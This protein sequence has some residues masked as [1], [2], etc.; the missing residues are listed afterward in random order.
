MIPKRILLAAGL[1]L[2]P[3]LLPAPSSARFGKNKVHYRDFEW[4]TIET[5]HF[6]IYYYDGEEE[7]AIRAARMAERA[8]Q[9]LSRILRHEIEEAVPV[10][11]YASHTDF[12]QTNITPGLIPEGTGGITEFSKRRV[13]LPFTGSYGEFDH[14]LTHEL[15]HAFQIDVLFG[16]GTGSNPFSFQPPL[17]FMEGMAE[18]LSIGKMDAHTEMW[19]RWTALEG[20]LIP[21]QYMNR[22][23]DIRVYRIGQAVW[24]FIGE[25]YGDEKI[26]EILRKSVHFRSVEMAFEKTLGVDLATLN[27]EWE[28]Y[29]KRKYF[30]TIVDLHRPEEHGRKLLGRE[31]SPGVHLAPAL[32]P[33][34][35]RVVFIKD[36]N[37]SKDIVMASAI[38]GEILDTL[39][40]GERSGDFESL[41]FFYTAIGWSPDGTRLAFPAKKGG[42]D[43][44]HVLAVESKEILATFRLGMDAIYSP[45]FH[46][47]GNRIVFSGSRGGKSDL[48]LVDLESGDLTQVTDDPHMARDPQWSPDGK[49]IA[50]VTDRGAGTDLENL[51]F[52]PPQVAI[53]DVGTGRVSLL[54]GQVGK[55]I[56]PQWGPEGKHLAF[57]SDR[58]GVSDIYVQ[59]LETDRLHRLT[60]L[61]T[62]VT[63]IIE[64]SPPISWSRSGQRMVFTTFTGQGWELYEIENPLRKMT[65]IDQFEP[66]ERIAQREPGGDE[67]WVHPDPATEDLLMARARP[68]PTFHDLLEPALPSLALAGPGSLALSAP[69]PPDP[70]MATDESERPLTLSLSRIIAE[71]SHELPDEAS[72]ESGPYR[73]KWSPDFV[74]A[75]PFFASN[76]GF[77]GSAQIAL[78]DMLSNHLVLIGASVYGSFEDSDL[79]LAYSNL[80]HRTNWGVAAFQYRNDFGVYTAQDR[81]GFASQIFRGG[82]AHVSRPFSKFTRIEL[83][84][85]AVSVSR[86][87]FEQ[88]FSG[89][90]LL[91]D[92]IGSDRF[93][94]YGPEIALVFDNVIYGWTG[95]MHGRR[96]RYSVEQALGDLE[97]TTSI[98]DY[99][100]YF[101]IGRRTVVALRVIGGTSEGKTPQLFRVGGPETLRGYDYGEFEGENIGLL[102]LEYRFPLVETL[103]LG[104]PLRIGLGGINGLLF[105]D[106]GG[107]WNDN[108]RIMRDGRF[109]D[110]G[111]DFGFGFRLGLGYFALKY[112]IAHRWDFRQTLG[113]PRSYFSIGIDY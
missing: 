49:G 56:S 61:V 40:E 44:L 106:M 96:A 41:R 55:G 91:A 85:Q 37:F 110:I 33:D 78:S 58:D 88:S 25:R 14:V 113:R 76:V 98:G 35:Q 70:A 28:E 23:Y 1:L 52:G 112:D 103:R 83:A 47:D 57:V 18:Y 7:S 86:R 48:Y 105:Y 4:R 46:P 109:D 59:E 3:I 104:W 2:L 36:G 97:F 66:L 42:E 11:V 74:G 72:L 77:A 80:A 87:V 63:G 51:L 99:R 75:S 19:L 92:E 32:S 13:F 107:A 111:A 62:G 6:D 27:E 31:Q 68:E 5:E 64:S 9:R 12:Q 79:L 102:N 84:V 17:W 89:G 60:R 81:T 82:Q 22:I 30:P 69:P 10:I 50:F 20:Q 24:A 54:P 39:V 15:V 101:P 65:E 73:L 71:T 94:Y 90:V 43:V 95:P 100:R 21:L 67:P 38:D 53:L 45:S 108:A 93:W 16:A 26:G 8:Y 29:V 34:G